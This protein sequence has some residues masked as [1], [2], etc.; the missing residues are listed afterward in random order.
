[1]ISHPRRWQLRCLARA[2]GCGVACAAAAAAAAWTAIAGALAA[3]AALVAAAAGLALWC[4]K[5]WHAAERNRVGADSEAAVRRRLAPLRREGWQ[6]R[7]ARPRPGG[8]DI[9]HVVVS[10]AGR[11][12]L[13]ETKTRRY[14]SEDLAR[15]RGAAS[16]VP[17]LC[18]ARGKGVQHHEGPVLVVSLD[19]LVPA[20]RTASR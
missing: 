11:R 3:T 5:W 2:V 19:R 10:P 1:M 6:V 14:T 4:R 12:F 16:D 15:I 9:D 18:V 8:G 20:L 17:V 7:H 13:I